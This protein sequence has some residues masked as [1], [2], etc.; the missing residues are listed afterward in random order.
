MIDSKMRMYSRLGINPT[1]LPTTKDIERIQEALKNPKTGIETVQM[2]DKNNIQKICFSGKDLVVWITKYYH[3]HSS[4]QSLDICSYLLT[5][6]VFKSLNKEH[7]DGEFKESTY[8]CFPEDEFDHYLKRLPDQQLVYVFSLIIGPLG[9]RMTNGSVGDR[10]INASKLIG[11]LLKRFS[12]INNRSEAARF[13]NVLASRGFLRSLD[14]NMFIIANV[15]LDDLKLNEIPLEICGICT[16]FVSLLSFQDIVTLACGH[17]FHRACLAELQHFEMG[18][19]SDC[20][21]NVSTIKTNAELDLI[22]PFIIKILGSSNYTYVKEIEQFTEAF[23]KK[24][25]VVSKEPPDKTLKKALEQLS[26]FVSKLNDTLLND[27]RILN[28]QDHGREKCLLTIKKSVIPKIYSTLFPLY[29]KVNEAKDTKL[30][31]KMNQL[32]EITLEDLEISRKFRLDPK[33]KPS[34]PTPGIGG[35]S[36]VVVNTGGGAP[37]RTPSV[38]PHH[39]LR[40]SASQMS[41][42]ST[43]SSSLTTDDSESEPSGTETPPYTIALEEFDRLEDYMDVYDKLNCLILTRHYIVDAIIAYW[44]ARGQFNA[45]DLAMDS[46]NLIGILAYVVIHSSVPNLFSEMNFIEDFMDE[47]SIHAEPGYCLTTMSTALMYI[48]ESLEPEAIKIKNS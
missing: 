48:C 4:S 26:I 18:R 3:F 2:L 8:Y 47:N 24:Y 35:N 16:K 14:N 43:A 34:V 7:H 25:S 10:P 45:E 11:W 9:I 37:K 41:V 12:D 6:K 28:Q 13:V 17:K 42:T 15:P 38:T 1:K 32:K 20:D 46:D 40:R 23:N 31:S 22:L 21:S 44:K 27:L 39:Q 5:K 33:Y 30:T 36:T 29:M 19:C